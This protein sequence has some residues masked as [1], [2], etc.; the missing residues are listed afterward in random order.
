MQNWVNSLQLHEHTNW[1]EN[2]QTMNEAEAGAAVVANWLSALTHSRTYTHTVRHDLESEA[3]G[4]CVKRTLRTNRLTGPEKRIDS[5]G[6]LA[7]G[8]R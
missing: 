7:R 4:K 5:G 1:S 2:E 3:R 6:V 8:N